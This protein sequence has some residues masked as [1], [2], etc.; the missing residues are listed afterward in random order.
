MCYLQL[1]RVGG[2]K[3]DECGQ[4][5]DTL[6]PLNAGDSHNMACQGF[7]VALVVV[8]GVG[9]GVVVVVVVVCFLFLLF[10]EN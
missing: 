1:Y 4:T 3:N 6:D 2:N 8:V 7:V 10:L 5:K 9:V